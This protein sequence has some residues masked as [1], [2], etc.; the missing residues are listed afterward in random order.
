MIVTAQKV[1]KNQAFVP[2]K[3]FA[4]QP[5]SAAVNFHLKYAHYLLADSPIIRKK[6]SKQLYEFKLEFW[7]NATRYLR[8]QLN[9]INS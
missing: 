3:I 6:T 8:I 5:S 4:L 7:V 1:I 9:E 2:G